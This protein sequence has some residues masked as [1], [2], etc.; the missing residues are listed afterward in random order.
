M[1]IILQLWIHL[2]RYLVVYLY[3]CACEFDWPIVGRVYQRKRRKGGDTT[4]ETNSTAR[5]QTFI[6]AVNLT[7]ALMQMSLALPPL[8][9]R[10]GASVGKEGER[11]TYFV[12]SWILF[13]IVATPSSAMVIGSVLA[14]IQSAPLLGLITEKCQRV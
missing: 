7:V 5:L 1:Y 11:C 4:T 12:R 10:V 2:H 6:H 13:S 8:H 3:Q 9:R 14:I